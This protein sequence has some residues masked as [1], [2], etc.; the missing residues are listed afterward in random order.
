MREREVGERVDWD[1]VVDFRA[2]PDLNLKFRSGMPDVE[3]ETD[4]G[5]D[6]V[7][8]TEVVPF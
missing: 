3:V 4:G 7:V 2:M 8:P 1:L 5:H 6:L